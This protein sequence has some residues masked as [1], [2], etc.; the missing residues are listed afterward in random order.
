MLW[1]SN[2]DGKPGRASRPLEARAP[3][4]QCAGR[5]LSMTSIRAQPEGVR[6]Q[7]PHVD[8]AFPTLN[9][10]LEVKTQTH[11][12]PRRRYLI[13]SALYAKRPPH[14]HSALLL[15]LLLALARLGAAASALRCG[16]SRTD[17]GLASSGCGRRRGWRRGGCC[18]CC[19]ALG[20]VALGGAALGLLEG[21]EDAALL[22]RRVDGDRLCA[23]VRGRCRAECTAG[24]SA[25]YSAGC[26]AGAGRLQGRRGTGGQMQGQ[27]QGGCRAA[28]RQLQG[29]VVPAR[30][31]SSRPGHRARS[32]SSEI[33]LW[34]AGA[35]VWVGGRCVVGGC[36]G[37]GVGVG[38]AGSRPRS[39]SIPGD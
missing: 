27:L 26:S 2:R 28:A 31:P 17:A 33:R 22:Q 8:S 15:L 38:V 20:G 1:T 12:Q 11:S 4:R 14:A 25:G 9:R 5:I 34:V 29:R 37:V 24:Y 6:P 21:G 39:R 7:R 18:A 10:S 23:L 32:T 16:R 35:G 13:L 30:G 36:V 3:P 19:R